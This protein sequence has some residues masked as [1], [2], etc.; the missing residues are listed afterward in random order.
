MIIFSANRILLSGSVIELD[1]PILEVYQ[2]A[3]RILVLYDPDT[4]NLAFG[5]FKNLLCLN[6]KGGKLW[7][8][9]LPTTQSGDCYYK[10]KSVNPLI[11]YSINSY[12]CE[13]DIVSGK[14]LNKEFIK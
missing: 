14:I 3:D 1:Y 9:E 5:Q 2:L 12:I 11:A 6:L 4:Y 7:E 8:A 13:I 10:I